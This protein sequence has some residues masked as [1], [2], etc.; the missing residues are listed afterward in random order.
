[1]KR[2]KQIFACKSCKLRFKN[3]KW[4]F[5]K[6]IKNNEQETFYFKFLR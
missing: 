4:K 3:E 1:L 5:R 6:L 2:N